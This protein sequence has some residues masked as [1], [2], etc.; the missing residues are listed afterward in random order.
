MFI[1]CSGPAIGYCS[2]RQ[3]QSPLWLLQCRSHHCCHP[4]LQLLPHHLSCHRSHRTIAV[5]IA[6]T[7][8]LPCPPQCHTSSLYPQ[9]HTIMLYSCCHTSL[10][11]PRH[12]IIATSLPAVTVP[13]LIASSLSSFHHQIILVVIT[14][15]SLLSSSLLSFYC[16]H[17]HYCRFIVVIFASSLLMSLL[18][19]HCR[20]LIIVV[21]S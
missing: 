19:R 8:P 16:C 14:I 13:S 12:R 21:A 11:Y 20:A 18:S 15:S 2:Q 4:T 10:S 3:K 5:A 7:A 17:R 6:V 9:C 1:A